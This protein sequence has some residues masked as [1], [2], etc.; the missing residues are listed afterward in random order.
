VNVLLVPTRREEPL[1]LELQAVL[2]ACAGRA[3]NPVPVSA[4]VHALDVVEAAER[5]ARLGAQVAL[6][7]TP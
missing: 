6:P 3:A 5:S 1:R 7:L 4:G 2:D